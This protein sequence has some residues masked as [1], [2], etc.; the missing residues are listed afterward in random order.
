VELGSNQKACGTL[1]FDTGYPAL[2]VIDGPTGLRYGAWSENTKAELTILDGSEARAVES[3]ETGIKANASQVFFDGN[4]GD[5][6][7][8]L[9]GVVPYFAFDVL[10]DPGRNEIG[11]KPR[12]TVA[13][14]PEGRLIPSR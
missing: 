1:T 13:G 14:M 5:G 6:T 10:Y 3:F 7:L 4:G 12:A 9:A 11:L 2:D 8:I